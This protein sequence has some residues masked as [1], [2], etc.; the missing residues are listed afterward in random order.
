M[1]EGVVD[2]EQLLDMDAENAVKAPPMPGG[3]DRALV[4]ENETVTSSQKGTPGIKFT[5]RGLDPMSDVDVDRW[6]AYLES[7]VINKEDINLSDTFYLTPKAMF[8][9]KDFCLACGT[10]EAGKM[11]KLVA[12]AMKQTVLIEVKQSVSRD[13]K[14]VYSEIVGYTEDK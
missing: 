3:T 7:P 11:G 14:N 13:G 1:S 2:F 5:F 12:D 6:Q 9:L 10:G 8:R 4:S